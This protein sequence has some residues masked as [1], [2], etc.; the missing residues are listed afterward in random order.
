MVEFVIEIENDKELL[1][2]K[3]FNRQEDEDT[4][5]IT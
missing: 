3:T 2:N 4:T 5:V 1:N